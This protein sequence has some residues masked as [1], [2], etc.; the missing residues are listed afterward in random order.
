MLEVIKPS[1]KPNRMF[2]CT[3]TNYRF[4][5]MVTDF[6]IPDCPLFS[7]VFSCILK[8]SSWCSDSRQPESGCPFPLQDMEVKSHSHGWDVVL[9]L[10]RPGSDWGLWRPTTPMLL[11][12]VS[13]GEERW[14]GRSD[15]EYWCLEKTVWSTAELLS[16]V[17]SWFCSG[18]E[19]L[20]AASNTESLDMGWARPDTESL[21]LG[22]P[23]TMLNSSAF[24]KKR[25]ILQHFMKQIPDRKTQSYNVQK[26]EI[27]LSMKQP[28]ILATN[29]ILYQVNYR[30]HL[31]QS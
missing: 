4:S 20:W 23:I 31:L 6:R 1:H 26:T 13:G 29:P 18:R 28:F 2:S 3:Q 24:W 7:S 16:R 10:G 14:I 27:S 9:L 30:V 17:I 22:Y 19:S 5:F 11:I 25:Y 15:L 21:G 8:S 12:G